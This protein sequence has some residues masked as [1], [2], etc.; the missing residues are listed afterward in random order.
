MSPGLIQNNS[1]CFSSL[2]FQPAFREDMRKERM[3]AGIIV[4]LKKG[5]QELKTL[6]ACAI[7]KVKVNAD[8]VSPFPRRWPVYQKT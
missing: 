3:I 1:V 5:D 7:F 6:C 2:L 8:N 4:L